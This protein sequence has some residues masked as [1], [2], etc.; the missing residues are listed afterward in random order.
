ME[1][2]LYPFLPLRTNS[3]IRNPRTCAGFA[4]GVQITVIAHY[5]YDNASHIESSTPSR[6]TC[7]RACSALHPHPH[8]TTTASPARTPSAASL[9]LPP[10]FTRARASLHPAGNVAVVVFDLC[11]HQTLRTSRAR[12]YPPATLRHRVSAHAQR[13]A[14]VRRFAMRTTILQPPTILLPS[15]MLGLL[16]IP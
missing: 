9:A 6:M 10:S 13:L 16:I 3:H 7:G 14:H 11:P 1:Y 15:P 8:N 4:P 2:S 5:G 12:Q